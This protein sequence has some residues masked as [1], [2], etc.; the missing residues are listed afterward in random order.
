[1]L[2]HKIFTSV[3]RCYPIL[4]DGHLLLGTRNLRDALQRLRMKQEESGIGTALHSNPMLKSFAD[5]SGGTPVLY[6]IDALCI[7]QEDYDERSSQVMLMGSIYRQSTVCLVWLGEGDIFTDVA[8]RFAAKIKNGQRNSQRPGDVLS[9]PEPSEIGKSKSQALAA[10]FT[11]TW[12]TRLW[13]VQ[14]VMLAPVVWTQ[15]GTSIVGFDCILHLARY[16]LFT[17]TLFSLE[18]A[19]DGQRFSWDPLDTQSQSYT[20]APMFLNQLAILREESAEGMKNSFDHVVRMVGR[21]KVSDPRD[22]VYAILDIAAEFDT[23][24][25]K[26]PVITPNYKL[27]VAQVY[28]DAVMALSR[29]TS[30]S[31]HSWANE[32][33]GRP[34]TCRLGAPTWAEV[35]TS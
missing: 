28:I 23:K 11:R 2:C 9:F 15:C 19:E 5:L 32:T 17:R 34:R 22:K 1:M 33:R 6:W 26:A 3:A 14:E 4:C 10:L 31:W 27:S 24:L 29:I 21:N 18:P 16:V 30:L 8:F 13:I 20:H 25:G 35:S 12:F 7:N